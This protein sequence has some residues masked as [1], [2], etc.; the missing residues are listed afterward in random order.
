MNKTY[1]TFL[2]ICL[3]VAAVL[4]LRLSVLLPLYLDSQVRADVLQAV[5]SVTEANG[6]L[7][8][9]VSIKHI[10][11]DSVRLHYR[12]YHRGADELECVRVLFADFSSVPC[13]N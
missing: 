10:E 13:E 12:H 8:S 2:G 1:L 9:G 7:K 11:D 4:C 3:A 5:E 6:W